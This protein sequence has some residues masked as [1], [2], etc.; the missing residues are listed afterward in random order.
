MLAFLALAERPVPRGRLAEVVFGGA[1]D[2]LGAL[3][4]TLAELRRALGLPGILRGDPVTLELPAGVGLDVAALGAGDPS[5]DLIRGELLEGVRADAGPV[6]DAWLVVERRRLAAAGEDLLRDAALSALANG[7][8]LDGAALASRAVA[9]NPFD[10]D[11]HELLVRCLARAGRIG[12]ARHHATACDVLFARELGRPPDARVRRAAEPGDRAAA[13]RAA[14]AG[15]RAAS[16]GQLEAGRAALAAGAPEPGIACLRMACAEARACE[17]PAVLAPALLELGSA[18]VHAVRGR[19]Q[20][21]AALL[22]EALAVADGAG[23]AQTAVDACRELGYVEVMAGHPSSASRWLA[24]A[25]AEAITDDQRA[26]AL[27]VRGMALS[28]RAHYA[29]AIRLLGDAAT[30]A[31]ACGA[32]RRTA[33]S[34][35]LLGRALVLRGEADEAAA[36]V[37]EALAFIADEGWVAFRP[38]A[39]AVRA[40]AAL[41]QGDAEAAGR[42]FEQAF[43]TGCRLQDPCW[44]ALGARGLGL[45]EAAAGDTA[46]AMR[47]IRDAAG[48]AVRVS[49]PYVWVHAACL[50]SLAAVA[51]GAGAAEA[52]A[53]VDDL[54][55]LAARGDFRDLV[56]RAALLRGRMGV[57]A[58]LSAVLPL[59]EAIDSPRLHADLALG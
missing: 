24:R 34:L 50:E 15:D 16:L 42:L 31:R 39:E 45:L 22:H 5:T 57:P 52:P 43:T 11:A 8:P 21:G 55:R 58:G 48:R 54:E 23:D 4:W 29:A 28:D 17:D 14:G 3:R 6:F 19:D 35:A 37:D 7:R 12:E 47:R 2:P 44:E 33:F 49:D 51:V 41:A 10:E 18:L 20:E 59:A 27:A 53:I 9:S 30:T 1:D 26:A 13:E 38:F 36:V 25:T 46:A 40:E 32:V 56:V